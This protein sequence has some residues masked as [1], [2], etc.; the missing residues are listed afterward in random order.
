MFIISHCRECTV[1]SRESATCK[2][3]YEQRVNTPSLCGFDN[4][5]EDNPFLN[6]INALR[7]DFNLLKETCINDVCENH[8]N[9]PY[10]DY[11]EGCL[12]NDGC[13]FDNQAAHI[14]A[15]RVKQMVA[16]SCEAIGVNVGNWKEFYSC[17]KL[18]IQPAS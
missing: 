2:G 13:G 18:I 11:Y 4:R 8:L 1:Q 9:I 7:V 6:C 3:S 5:D 10:N 15:C 16:R 17:G 12:L 14:A